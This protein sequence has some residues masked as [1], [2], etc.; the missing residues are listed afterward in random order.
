MLWLHCRRAFQDQ[1]WRT[2]GRC[3]SIILNNRV[4]RI[5]LKI[6]DPMS[7]G[8]NPRHF[9]GSEKS[10]ILGTGNTWPSCHSVKSVSLRQYALKKLWS[11]SR[12]WF[13]RALKASA[14]TSLIPGN[15]PF[16]N[17]LTANLTSSHSINWLIPSTV[18]RG[19]M[20]SKDSHVMGQGERNMSVNSDE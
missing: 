20:W 9:F 12:F 4:H 11:I 1:T 17:F 18:S 15:F 19:G 13:E 2:V 5:L 14:G 3:L 8:V 6:L 7:I 10:P 16:A